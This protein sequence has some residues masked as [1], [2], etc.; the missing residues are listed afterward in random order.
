MK[1]QSYLG[2]TR[3]KE[4]VISHNTN[5]QAKTMLPTC[6]KISCQRSIKRKC[7]EILEDDRLR[8]FTDFWSNLSWSEKK[9]YVISLVKKTSVKQRKI[10]STVSRRNSSFSYF[11]KINGELLNVCK[12]MF[13]NTLALGESQVHNWCIT[14]EQCELSP[15][16]PKV[17]IC[18][19]DSPHKKNRKFVNKFLKQISKMPS[20]YC[21][22]S[23]SKLYLE[24]LEPY[25]QSKSQL[26]NMYIEMCNNEGK[27][28][29]IVSINTFYDI[30]EENNISLFSPKKDQCDSCCAYQTNNIS[31]KEWKDH[32]EDKNRSREEKYLDK[33]KALLNEIL[34]FTMDLQAVKVCPYLKASALYYKSKLCVHN[35]TTYNL[36]THESTC[37]WW[38]ETQSDLSASSFVSC[39]IDQLTE[40]HNKNPNLNIILWSDG[41][42]YQN[43]NNVLSN[44]L[45][46]FAIN[47]KVVIEQKYLT[48]G[49]TQMEC[50][51]VHSNIERKLKNADIYLPSDYFKITQSAR[52]KPFPYNVKWC[53]TSFFKQCQIDLNRYDSLRPGKSAGDPTVTN[54]KSI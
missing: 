24:R 50:D 13:L 15:N 35:F 5:R 21:R 53:D 44:A 41:C 30:V 23:T 36:A 34:V 3:S 11:L 45:L 37:Y 27:E 29:N 16:T 51:S 32:I 49:H 38:D 46:E 7:N 6:T 40:C 4:K 48:K 14:R 2:Y 42:C 39:I 54:I 28:N 9:I 33:E 47:N 1:G 20:H 8:V 43:R 18:L 26:Y 25:I 12:S 17:R 52:K 22:T 10:D 19:R 31:E